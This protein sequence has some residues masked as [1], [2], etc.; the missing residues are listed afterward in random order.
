VLGA[1]KSYPFCKA[2]R[3]CGI[4]PSFELRKILMLFG[5]QERSK[6]TMRGGMKEGVFESGGL[7]LERRG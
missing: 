3:R 6:S 2:E 1:K 4:V 7:N 5:F